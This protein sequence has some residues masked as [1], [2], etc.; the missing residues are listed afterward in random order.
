[1]KNISKYVLSNKEEEQLKLGLTA[2][3]IKA[4]RGIR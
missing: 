3:Q 4:R 2:L 1:M